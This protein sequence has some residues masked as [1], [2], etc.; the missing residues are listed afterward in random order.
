MIKVEIEEKLKRVIEVD[1]DSNEEA[2]EFVEEQYAQG[3]IVLDSSDFV[4]FNINILN[5]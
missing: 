3:N 1:V 2:H 5:D 4:E